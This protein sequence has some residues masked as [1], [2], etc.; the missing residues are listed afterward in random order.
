MRTVGTPLVEMHVEAETDACTCTKLTRC[1]GI[2][3]L[4][5]KC[6]EHGADCR[7]EGRFHTHAKQV[8]RVNGGHRWI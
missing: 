6:P 5:I 4:D 3:V 2:A 7:P 8:D 1:G